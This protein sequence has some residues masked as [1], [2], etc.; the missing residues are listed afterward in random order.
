M[1][2]A[3]GGDDAKGLAPPGGVRRQAEP[4]TGFDALPDIARVRIETVAALLACSTATV[5]RRV[6][7]GTVP[8]PLR[9]G[10]ALVWRAGDLRRFLA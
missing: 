10:G 5:R 8:K 6:C 4:L 1:E 2:N 9:E 3:I 7:A